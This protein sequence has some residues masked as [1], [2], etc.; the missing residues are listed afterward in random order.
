MRQ[1]VG[2][3]DNG[4][5][6]LVN[7]LNTASEA[8]MAAVFDEL[9]DGQINVSMRAAT[10]YDVSQI[11]LNLGG[12]GHAQAAGCTLGGPLDAAR[13]HVLSM[14]HEAWKAQTAA[15]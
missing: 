9:P 5:A 11:A 7:F 4:D 6:G 14:L 15:R 2:Y 1:Q 3:M 10:R 8:D 12:G 13:D